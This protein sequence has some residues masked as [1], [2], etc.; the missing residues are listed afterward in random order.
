MWAPSI[1]SHAQEPRSTGQAL[2]DLASKCLPEVVYLWVDLV[3]ET[4]CG[5]KV[6]W[7]PVDL[8]SM[9]F[10][11]TICEPIELG[12]RCGKGGVEGFFKFS[13]SPIPPLS[14]QLTVTLPPRSTDPTLNFFILDWAHSGGEGEIG[15]RTDHF[16]GCFCYLPCMSTHFQHC[17]STVHFE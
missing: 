13:L 15:G 12:A 5:E 10:A 9:A 4:C 17:C 16:P 14:C 7:C 2:V 11:P 3:S 6:Y 1:S 8:A